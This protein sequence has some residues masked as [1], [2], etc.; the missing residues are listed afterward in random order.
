MSNRFHSKFHRQNHHTY[1]SGTNPDA[2]HDPIASR[3]QPFRGDFVLSGALSCSAPT[4]AVAGF[5]VTNN[6]ALC[7]IG[8]FRGL[9][10]RTPVVGGEFLS[11]AGNAISAYG[12]LIGGDFYSRLRGIRARGN[13]YG[14]EAYSTNIANYASGVNVGTYSVSPEIA[15]SVSSPLTGAIIDGDNIS[16]ATIGDGVNV[17]RNRTGIQK[18]PNASYGTYPLTNIVLDLNGDLLVEGNTLIT[19]NLSAIGDRTQIDAIIQ[20]TSSLRVNNTGSSAAATIVQTGNQPIL[21]CY[22][23]EVSLSVPSFIVDGGTNG[24]VGIGIATPTAPFTIQKSTANNQG[25]NQP[26]VR[27]TDNG[28]TNIVTIST[29]ITNHT[30]SHIGTESN[31]NFDIIT[32]DT[33]RITI[34]NGGNVGI[35]ATSPGAK[36]TVN[37]SISGNS[38][39]S[40]VGAI[41]GV[42]T[43]TIDGDILGKS[44]L[45][46]YG[47]LSGVSTLTV[48]GEITGKSSLTI[49]G[50]TTLGNDA[51]DTVTIN[52]GPISLVNATQTSDAL[53]FGSGANLANL[54]RSANDT[55]KTDDSLIVGTNLTTDGDITG[56]QKITSYGALSS[57]ST[58]TVDSTITG[59]ST[60]TA[61]TSLSSYGGVYHIGN[62][63]GAVPVLVK[64]SNINFLG[65]TNAIT[66]LYDVPQGFRFLPTEVCV[67]HDT[68]SFTGGVTNSV[69]V[70][71]TMPTFRLVDGSNNN[72]FGTGGGTWFVPTNGV[73]GYWSSAVIAQGSQDSFQSTGGPKYTVTS[74][75]TVN[76]KIQSGWVV[77]GITNI[78][79]WNST[80]ILRG[81]L[82]AN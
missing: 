9:Y 57:A 77:S 45:T 21:A 26:Q 61:Q 23:D 20:I 71:D 79:S 7:A 31:T 76:F 68:V 27:I 62:P 6:T 2:G 32:N 19:G 66:K 48:D 51:S 34:L 46:A 11:T 36:L 16:L 38:T 67:I 72:L 54:Y 69:N 18:I 81:I 52:A 40:N 73:A 17:L 29:P 15:L 37:G 49:D 64:V 12:D 60:I 63:I 13:T 25:N 55:L 8:G 78:T 35:G 33:A 1:T 53:E 75:G 5:F 3:E 22:D 50:N 58:L 65:A 41:S 42:T 39:F 82:V 74:G 28:S 4:S 70:T 59:K 80:V 43:L 56:K 30:R 24:W 44:K 10:V 14:V 47:A